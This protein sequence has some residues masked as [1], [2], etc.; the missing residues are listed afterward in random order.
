MIVIP[1]PGLGAESAE[2]LLEKCESSQSMDYCIGYITG[3]YDGRTTS[4]YGLTHLMSCPPQSEDG[5]SIR[6]TYT[7]MVR[8]FINWAQNN[9]DKLHF[10][11][12]QAVRSA[13][14]EAWPCEG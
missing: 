5:L 8:V 3:F 13:F 1:K 4:D 12:W 11:D 9:P 7:Q 14:A 10:D 6:V 2:Q